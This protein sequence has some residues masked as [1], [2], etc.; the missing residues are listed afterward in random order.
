MN[1]MDL[2]IKVSENDERLLRL[3]IDETNATLYR[4]AFPLAAI[5]GCFTLTSLVHP[6]SRFAPLV[7]NKPLLWIGQRSYGIYLW[8]WVIFQIMRPGIDLA[9]DA[10]A[11]NAAA[12]RNTSAEGA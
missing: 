10:W 9:G 11:I 1:Y 12:S 6:A 2:S 7:S 8:H 4:I 3:K 5:F